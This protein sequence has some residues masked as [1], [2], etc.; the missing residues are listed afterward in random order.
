LGKVAQLPGSSTRIA[1]AVTA[2]RAR[3]ERG[4]VTPR[5]LASGSGWR[6]L[7]VLCTCDAG[8]HPAEERHSHYSLAMVLAGAFHYRGRSGSAYLPAGSILLGRAGA[9][10]QCWHDQGAGD[11]CLAVQFESDVFEELADPSH[12]PAALRVHRRTAG[13][14]ACAE[15]IATATLSADEGLAIAMTLADRI[16]Q[17]ANDSTRPECAVKP[18]DAARVLDLVRWIE[19]DP[20]AEHSLPLLARRAGMSRFHLVRVFKQVVGLPPHAFIRRA[21]LRN[22]AADLAASERPILEIALDA[23]FSDVSTFNAAFRQQFACAPRALRQR[24]RAT[25]GYVEVARQEARGPG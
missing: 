12:W 6:I 18:R 21:R 5:T 10:F 1:D 11:R 20:A 25:G 22:A 13:L 24:L 8:D 2:R 16:V 9:P 19:T 14:F 23:G 7:D 17:L 4:T 3:G 15:L